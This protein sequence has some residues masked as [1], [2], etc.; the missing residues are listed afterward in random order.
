M[1]KN[2][3]ISSKTN[4]ENFNK[5][6]QTDE[7]IKNE[8]C[9]DDEEIWTE[10]PEVREVDISTKRKQKADD[11]NLEKEIKRKCFKNL[12]KRKLNEGENQNKT[13][14]KEKKQKIY[15]SESK[16]RKNSSDDQQTAECLKSIL[17]SKLK[18]KSGKKLKISSYV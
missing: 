7:K 14:K 4:A 13:K 11:V 5:S 15:A 1:K 3:S 17:K 12:K 2:I 8:I 18:K 10:M 6:K 9:S 16:K